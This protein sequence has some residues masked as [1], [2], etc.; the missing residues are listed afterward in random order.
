MHGPYWVERS[1]CRRIFSEVG[2][3]DWWTGVKGEVS[4]GLGE[5]GW[6]DGGMD[7]MGGG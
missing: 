3:R 7:E 2:R 4:L 1:K 5:E 6:R